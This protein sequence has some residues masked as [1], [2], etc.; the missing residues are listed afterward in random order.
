VKSIAL[1][2]ILCLVS[3]GM[4]V[5]AATCNASSTGVS[6]G[7]Y[8]SNQLAPVDS[9]G[10]INISCEKSALDSLPTTVTYSIDLSR[11]GSSS[12]A[13]RDLTGTAGTL[14]YN[15]Y[16]DALHSTIWGDTTGGTSD[17]TGTLQLQVPVGSAATTHSIYGRVFG[18]QNALP[19]S[20]GDSIVIT[21]VY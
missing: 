13:A 9:V 20:Y 17:A 10:R 1:I 16:L 21:V 7:S 19:G 15:L 8:T 3:T 18:S 4:P 2:G 6:L 12:Y 14:H 5:T 11:G